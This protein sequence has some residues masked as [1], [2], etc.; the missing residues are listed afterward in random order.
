MAMNVFDYWTEVTR[1]LYRYE[2]APYVAYEIH[3]RCWKH[4]DDIQKAKCDLYIFGEWRDENGSYFS[5]RER[6][7]EDKTPEECIQEA[8]KDNEENNS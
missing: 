4:K 2:I 6:I 1:G 5:E 7:C 3:I 8:E